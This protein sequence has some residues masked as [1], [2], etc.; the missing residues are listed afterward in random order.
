MSPEESGRSKG[1]S[2]LYPASG[3]QHPIFSQKYNFIQDEF[4]Q[5]FV[6]YITPVV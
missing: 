6:I 1:I 3:I 5:G 2:I 4:P